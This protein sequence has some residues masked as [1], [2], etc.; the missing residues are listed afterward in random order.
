MRSSPGKGLPALPGNQRRRETPQE[1]PDIWESVHQFERL[2]AHGQTHGHDR[3]AGLR[4]VRGDEPAEIW[5]SRVIYPPLG[6]KSSGLRYV[7]ERLELDG[8]D[9][10]VALTIYIHQDN[11]RESD[12]QARIRERFTSYEATLTGLRGLERSEVDGDE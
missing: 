2:L 11:I 12:I 3:Y 5:K 4:L 1:T 7:Y 10:A 6:G 8:E 9:Y